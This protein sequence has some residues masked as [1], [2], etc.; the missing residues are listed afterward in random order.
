MTIKV[1]VDEKHAIAEGPFPL[2]FVKI[3]ASLGGKKF[4]MD[5]ARVKFESFPANLEKLR[6]SDFEIEFDDISGKLALLERMANLPSQHD[7]V[8]KR[9]EEYKLSSTELFRHQ[10]KAFDLSCDREY[11]A[12]FLEMGLGKSLVLIVTTGY[13]HWLGKV[14]GCLILSPKGVHRQWAKEQIPTHISPDTK[15]RTLIWA[16]KPFSDEQ[17]ISATGELVFLCMNTDAAR[18]LKGREVMVRFLTIHNKKSMMAVDESHD[19]KEW[20]AQ[21]TNAVVWLGQY[22]TY[23]RILT[24]TP[25]NKNIVDTFSQFQFLNQD[26][27]GHKYIT[28]FK[29]EFCIFNPERKGE[30]VGQKNTERFYTRVAPHMFRLTKTECLD[31]PPKLYVPKEYQ[32]SD[33]V[34]EHYRSL[35]KTLMAEM[36]DGTIVEAANAAVALGKL[37]QVVNGWLKDTE[38]GIIHYIDT[39]RIEYLMDMI[40]QIEGPIIVWVRFIEDA[41]RISIALRK[42]GISHV[43]YTGAESTTQRSE[44]VSRFLGGIARVFVSNPA[45]GGVGLNLQG[46]CTTAIYYSNSFNAKDRWQ[47]EDRLHRIGTIGAVTYFDIIAQGTIDRH[48]LRNLREKKSISDLTFDEIRQAI[49]EAEL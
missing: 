46:K 8:V 13:L 38:T 5:R 40:D 16:G 37:Q 4:W 43:R 32:V 27:T 33:T 21:R 20:S 22:A 17:L 35:R 19:I 11:Y 25:I 28:T 42:E 10:E 6:E 31:L 23:R 7:I 15:Y 29:A 1:T 41:Q 30:V 47:S 48:V 9:S 44:A 36:T 24:G 18:T 34:K 26:I 12:L 39:D 14:T 45:A 2:P 49:A 3:I